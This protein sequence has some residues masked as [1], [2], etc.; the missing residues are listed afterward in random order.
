MLNNHLA[1]FAGL[2]IAGGFATT[3][4]NAQIVFSEDFDDAEGQ[5][6]ADV[7]PDVGDQFRQP[8]GPAVVVESGIIDTTGEARTIFG[9]FDA[10]TALSASSPFLDVTA[11]I[12]LLS[13]NGG[14][15][16]IS[17]FTGTQEQFFFGDTGLGGENDFFGIDGPSI[18]GQLSDTTDLG[19]YTFRYDFN[20]GDVALYSGDTA[21][22]TPVVSASGAAGL[23]FDRFR[24]ENGSG[25]DIAISSINIAVNANAVPEPATVTAG[26]ALGMGL[27]ARRRR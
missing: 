18:T 12:T 24:I 15:A 3:A 25:G 9:D 4:A 7:V 11:D 1:S 8:G 26:L 5:N 10:T 13:L 20:T 23:N 17:L 14:Y 6:V 2:L 27:L 19:L 21:S 16:G 22:G